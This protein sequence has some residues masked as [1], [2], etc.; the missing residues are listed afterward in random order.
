M[1][2]TITISAS[3][4]SG[5]ML[6][7]AALAQSVEFSV[8]E[9]GTY[10][11]AARQIADELSAAGGPHV[12]V[13]AFPWEVLRQTNTTDLIS[14][15]NR[16][17]VM[18]GGYYL[19][20]VYPYFQGLDD[21]I[22]RDDFADGMIPNLMSPGRSEFRDGEQIGIP[23]G[24]DSYG[25]IVNTDLLAA[26]GIGTEFA[27]WAAVIAACPQ[28]EEATG[29]ACLSH[30]TGSPEQIGAFF[31][32]GYSGT[33]IDAGGNYALDADAATA[34]A[35]E[36]AA[37]WSFLPENGTAMS[38]DEAHAA[39]A[40][41]EAALLVT[42]PSFTIDTLDTDGVAAKGHWQLVNFPGDGFPWLSLWQLFVPAAVE[43][44]EAAWTWIKAF[45]GPEHATRNLIEH[46]FG[47]V[48]VSTY[49]DEAL[50]AERAH[51]W[52]AQI[53][54]FSRAKNPPLSGEA[55][56]FLTNTLQ[57]IAN[58]RISAADGIAMVNETWGTLPVPPAL[59][60]AANGSGLAAD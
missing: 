17:D 40:N 52:P 16:F 58:G 43:D 50:A 1:S 27:D 59:L 30:P 25:L 39:F 29:V 46:N 35:G 36:I 11:V 31:F 60:E 14:G 13:S 44:R 49:E 9:S 22:A 19:A 10:D 7:G 57:E 55:Q 51:F 37:L 18:S 24:I 5:M 6:S 8:M 34:V 23:Y 45:A 56:D 54:G 4:L 32:S 12:I 33:Y 47:S 26:A 38:F 21:L 48:W 28:I 42:W 2:K 53:E 20:D 41:G 3:V 15:T